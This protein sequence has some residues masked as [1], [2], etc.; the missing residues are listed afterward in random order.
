MSPDLSS[1]EH[2]LCAPPLICCVNTYRVLENGL[3][4][5]HQL[6]KHLLCAPTLGCCV[7]TYCVSG[8]GLLCEQMLC[9]KL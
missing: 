4:C 9:A 7:N 8:I 2:L 3:L 6:C 1:C 5:G